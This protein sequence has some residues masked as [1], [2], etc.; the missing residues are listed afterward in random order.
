[1]RRAAYVS[2]A[3]LLVI[4]PAVTALADNL[5]PA[6]SLEIWG[7]SEA[8]AEVPDYVCTHPDPQD[9]I[10]YSALK[11]PYG[12]AFFAVHVGNL[13]DPLC[14][15]LGMDCDYHGGYSGLCFGIAQSGQAA[16][17]LGFEACPGFVISQLDGPE[18]VLVQTVDVC[19]G[20]WEHPGYF[21]YSNPSSNV[22]GTYFRIVPNADLGYCKVINCA[23]GFDETR[24]AN[25]ACWEDPVYSASCTASCGSLPVESTT[26]GKIKSLFR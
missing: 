15:T 10:P 21:V 19:R 1:M 9:E 20:T 23:F 25:C 5:E 14:P 17:F 3:A 11:S 13:D 26:W 16:V 4:G 12:C 24:V 22:G 6:L 7:F 8:P 2:F 18:A